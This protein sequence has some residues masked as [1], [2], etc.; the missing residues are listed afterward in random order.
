MQMSL[1]I[2]SEAPMPEHRWTRISKWFEK[3]HWNI[4]RR[5]ITSD[6]FLFDHRPDV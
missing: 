3:D 1:T 5:E 4:K 6:I 2:F